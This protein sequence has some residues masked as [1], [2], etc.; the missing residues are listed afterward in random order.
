MDLSLKNSAGDSGD[1]FI[2]NRK[3]DGCLIGRRGSDS[4]FCSRF[5]REVVTLAQRL[6]FAVFKFNAAVPGQNNDPL[7]G[8]LVIPARL[9]RTVIAVR[10]DSF[11][12]DGFGGY[13]VLDYLFWGSERPIKRK[14]GE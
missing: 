11:D 5:D 9:W 8:V 3:P 7:M 10:E 6:D 1:S 13:Q 12:T 2:K 14:V 4:V